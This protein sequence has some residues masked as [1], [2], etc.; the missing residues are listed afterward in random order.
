MF[1]IYIMGYEDSLMNDTEKKLQYDLR[2]RR[3]KFIGDSIDRIG[4][5]L[6]QKDY[7]ESWNELQLLYAFSEH[8]YKN[9]EEAE[10][11]Y[12]SYNETMEAIANEDALVWTGK[13]Y[14]P[15]Q[16]KKIRIHFIL[17]VRFLLH[18]IDESGGFGTI[19]TDV[20]AGF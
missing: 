15:I 2:Q 18:E 9:R 13:S 11:Q 4:I 6:R 7:P 3:E 19:E 17:F 8:L 14:D 20:T 12:N 1:A 16:I 5:L 10:K